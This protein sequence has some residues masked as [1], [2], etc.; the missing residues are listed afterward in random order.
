M[1]DHCHAVFPQFFGGGRILEEA[2]IIYGTE[3]VQDQF[4][5]SGLPNLGLNN[6]CPD[7]TV[8]QVCV[9][10]NDNLPDNHTVRGTCALPN[11]CRGHHPHQQY[12]ADQ[13]SCCLHKTFAHVTASNPFGILYLSSTISFA[14]LFG[15]LGIFCALFQINTL[16][17]QP[18]RQ[19]WQVLQSHTGWSSALFARHWSRHSSG[20]QA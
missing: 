14:L 9:A 16:V 7:H 8:I 10:L 19:K 11:C 5:R 13:G 2:R 15:S 17:P 18:R 4:I 12:Q 1:E 6:R 3:I 20:M